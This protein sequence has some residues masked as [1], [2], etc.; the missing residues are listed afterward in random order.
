MTAKIVAETEAAK[1]A[2]EGGL[3][4]LKDAM[5]HQNLKVEAIEVMVSTTGFERGNEE[6]MANEQRSTGRN[7]RKL[8]L[9]ESDEE[10]SLEE[11]AEA[12]K[13]KA[14]GSSVSYMA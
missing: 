9:S 8:D 12:E 7:R 1:Q 14:S 10:I 6:Q 3:T 11:E 5:Q 4:N 2:I 13:M